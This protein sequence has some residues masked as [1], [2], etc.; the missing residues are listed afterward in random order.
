MLIDMLEL[1][2]ICIKYAQ[3][4][5][6]PVWSFKSKFTRRRVEKELDGIQAQQQGNRQ[7]TEDAV[8]AMINDA[9]QN[10]RRKE[11]AKLLLIAAI[12]RRMVSKDKAIEMAKSLGIFGEDF[13]HYMSQYFGQE[14]NTDIFDELV[15]KANENQLP[16]QEKEMQLQ[17]ASLKNKEK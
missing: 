3:F 2:K 14:P 4:D 17:V 16:Q 5:P 11:F 1:K 8:V 6:H 7:G 12:P 10:G 13:E 15:G 9:S